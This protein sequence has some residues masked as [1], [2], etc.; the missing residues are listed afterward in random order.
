MTTRSGARRRALAAAAAAAF[1]AM[2]C[3]SCA[4]GAPPRCPLPLPVGIVNAATPW[5]SRTLTFEGKGTLNAYMGDDAIPPRGPSVRF[6]KP[7]RS[8]A[9]GA[10]RPLLVYL[11]PGYDPA[12]PA[13]PVIFAVHGFS[14]RPQTWGLLLLD[15]LE[16]AIADGVIPPLV[17]AMPDVSLSGNGRD[18]R[19]TWYDDRSGSFGINSNR[20]R[21]E[22]HFFDEVAPFVFSS[23]NVRRDPR[24]VVLMGS[25]MGGFCVLYYGITRPGFSHILVP[26]YPC[27]DL[28]YGVRGRKLE[29]YDPAGYALIDNDNPCRVVN[30]SQLGGAVGLTEK[31]LYYPVFDSDRSPGPAWSEDLPVW[32]RLSDVNPVEILDRG[33]V[34]LSGQG[35]YLVVGSQD[36]FN[37]D[38][39]VPLIVPRLEA[40]GAVVEPAE[41]VL[42]AGRHS[43]PFI[44]E[45]LPAIFAWMG[46]QLAGGPADQR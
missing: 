1:A 46:R 24:G 11:P 34:D 2:L 25:S 16:A 21:F 29:N 37:L 4:S 45:N 3:L 39:H 43:Q 6:E 32:K 30:A 18:D 42:P 36:D 33:S 7:L 14:S 12:G 40:H 31:W 28:R 26:I 9:L 41:H 44:T 38:A 23:F 5:E 19:R 20:G 35:Y 13:Y 15:A 10:E 8:G 17:V 22:D 27:A